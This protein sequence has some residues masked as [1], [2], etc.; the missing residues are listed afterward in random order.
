LSEQA[1]KRGVYQVLVLE[2]GFVTDESR[3][4]VKALF[5][6]FYVPLTQALE[7]L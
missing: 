1:I 3:A 6:E 5:E 7:E 4:E 2:A